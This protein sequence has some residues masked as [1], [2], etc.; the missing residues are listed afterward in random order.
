[1]ALRSFLSAKLKSTIVSM[2]RQAGGVEI[3][4]AVDKSWW[5]KPN[6]AGRKDLR[7]CGMPH[8]YGHYCS[9]ADVCD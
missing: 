1:M 9:P 7:S 4:D 5:R 6:V 3:T 8:I 2:V